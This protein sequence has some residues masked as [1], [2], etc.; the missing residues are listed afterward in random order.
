VPGEK[1]DSVFR[2][3]V[4]GNYGRRKGFQYLLQARRELGLDNAELI[5]VGNPLDK[6]KSIVEQYRDER[7][8]VFKAYTPNIVDAYQ[9]SSLF[10]FPS[11]LE[12]SAKVTYEAMAC[13]LPV[14]CTYESGS[15][16]RDGKDGYIVPSRSVEAL[17]EKIQYFYDHPDRLSE[18]G[19]SAR[20]YMVDNYQWK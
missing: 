10:V 20:S 19:K 18:M 14:V 5:V 12:G 7:S 11:L 4:A 9:Q 1:R 3:I 13:G 8:I 6:M 16:V 2:V 15:V 17:K